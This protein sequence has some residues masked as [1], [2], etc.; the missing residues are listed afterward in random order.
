MEGGRNLRDS[1]FGMRKLFVELCKESY[2]WSVLVQW[3][4][5]SSRTV[6]VLKCLWTVYIWELRSSR[7]NRL[8][9]SNIPTI[10]DG[11]NIGPITSSL[12][13]ARISKLVQKCLRPWFHFRRPG[14]N[15]QTP[16][17]PVRGVGS[18][19]MT[20]TVEKCEKTVCFQTFFR[21]SQSWENMAVFLV[22][23]EI[24]SKKMR[25]VQP[26]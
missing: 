4:L 5:Y 21:H 1:V 23:S 14:F 8:L 26:N 13:F 20:K 11:L 10:G 15:Q 12:T 7:F 18:I 9:F 2:T 16:K 3:P 25:S 6:I 22:A 17:G 24:N 19:K